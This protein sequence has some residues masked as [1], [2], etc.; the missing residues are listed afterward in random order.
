MPL[1]PPLSQKRHGEVRVDLTGCL[2]GLMEVPLSKSF[3]MLGNARKTGTFANDDNGGC[4]DLQPALLAPRLGGSL[5]ALCG[6]GDLKHPTDRLGSGARN[7]GLALSCRTQEF[8]SGLEHVLGKGRKF[9]P[10]RQHH[11]LSE[12]AIEL[13]A[14]RNYDFRPAIY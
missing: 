13:A 6:C 3:E 12:I 14:G 10:S 2:E 9:N 11:Y 8:T 1:G 5:E 4:G 7:V